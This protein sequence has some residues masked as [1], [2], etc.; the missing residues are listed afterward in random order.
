MMMFTTKV[1]EGTWS[2]AQGVVE[3]RGTLASL[4]QGSAGL[5]SQSK[6]G[7]GTE[8]KETTH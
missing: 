3:F 7:V 5:F 6:S 1:I 8:G 2:M 4:R